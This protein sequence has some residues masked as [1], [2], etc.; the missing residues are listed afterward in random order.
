MISFCKALLGQDV[1]VA[2]TGAPC[3]LEQ[4]MSGLRCPAGRVPG[5]NPEAPA[6]VPAFPHMDPLAG[7]LLELGPPPEAQ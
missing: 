1:M 6:I 3:I 7:S 5:F 2:S 4:D